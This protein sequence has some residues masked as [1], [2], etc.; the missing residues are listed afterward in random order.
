MSQLRI[1]LRYH[2]S[3]IVTAAIR[4]ENMKLHKSVIYK[5]NWR[6]EIV[7]EECSV[8][9]HVSITLQ[10]IE[11]MCD[12]S[13][14][15]WEVFLDIITITPDFKS[16]KC[17][18]VMYIHTELEIEGHSRWQF[19]IILVYLVPHCDCDINVDFV[20]RFFQRSSVMIGDVHEYSGYLFSSFI[21]SEKRDDL[22]RS[23][24]SRFHIL[25]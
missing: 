1:I 3:S 4:G 16:E 9:T 6:K 10:N 13:N 25:K 18:G 11:G 21:S 8:T 15:W 7:V 5:N 22:D 23:S 2:T 20:I 17:T 14:L 12:L 24:L 19:D